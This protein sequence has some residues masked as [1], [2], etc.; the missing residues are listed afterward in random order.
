MVLRV[1]NMHT[2]THSAQRCISLVRSIR[3]AV[4]DTHIHVYISSR[5]SSRISQF[6]FC[7]LW[8]TT[9]DGLI[10]HLS[11]RIAVN[12]MMTTWS[13]NGFAARA[14]T[15]FE[16]VDKTLIG[17]DFVIQF[18]LSASSLPS[19]SA[20]HHHPAPCYRS[21]SFHFDFSF[22]FYIT[23]AFDRQ[24]HGLICYVQF[25]CDDRSGRRKEIL[26]FISYT[27]HSTGHRNR[28]IHLKV[29]PF[30]WCH[31]TRTFL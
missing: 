19:S 23:F 15:K 2:H 5:Q 26:N 1:A 25:D 27:H 12:L 29:C 11:H 22:F 31:L 16:K 24:V 4:T 20:L 3:M 17:S 18:R 7:L 6:L 28:W 13:W 21:V 9:T 10:G 30:C 14:R 8:R